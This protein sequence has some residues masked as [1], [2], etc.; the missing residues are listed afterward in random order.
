MCYKN[1]LAVACVRQDD[2]IYEKSYEK[3]LKIIRKI[4]FKIKLEETLNGFIIMVPK[5]KKYGTFKNRTI[6][7]RIKIL[8]NQLKIRGLIFD[9]NLNWLE[10]SFRNTILFNGKSLMKEFISNIIEYIF[11][12]N[13]QNINMENVYIFVNEYNKVN[14]R[15]IK[16]LITRFKTVNIITENMRYYKRLENKLYYEGIL[17]TVSNNKRKSVRKSKYII[18][19]DFPNEVIKQFTVNPK[20]IIVNVSNEKLILDNS[21]NG[22]IVNDFEIKIDNNMEKYIKEF[23]GKINYKK[24]IEL[25]IN[26]GVDAEKLTEEYNIQIAELKGIRGL[27]HK[28]EFLL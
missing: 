25:C 20:A 17:I 1:K 7:K 11:S 26:Y 15:I 2:R 16:Q 14:E 28:C 18:N 23:Y 21:F 9:D 3:I 12:I 22:I 10:S 24:Y 8:Q 19:L 5:Y 27:L 13:N 4:F 6:I